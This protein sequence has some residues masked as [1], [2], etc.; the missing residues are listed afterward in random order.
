M[1]LKIL[2]RHFLK[3]YRRENLRKPLIYQFISGVYLTR[4]PNDHI[5]ETVWCLTKLLPQG[6]SLKGPCGMSGDWMI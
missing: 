4:F 6:R 1:K 5:K 3:F 2:F